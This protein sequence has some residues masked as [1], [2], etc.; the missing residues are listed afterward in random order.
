MVPDEVYNL[1]RLS[2]VCIRS[3]ICFNIHNICPCQGRC[4][5][6]SANV[7][8]SQVYCK[9]IYIGIVFPYPCICVSLRGNKCFLLIDRMH[10]WISLSRYDLF[11]QEAGQP[12]NAYQTG[13]SAFSGEQPPNEGAYVVKAVGYESEFPW[14]RS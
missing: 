14:T 6:H 12:D 5:F 10:P 4:Y 13:T 2:Y 7:N 9:R 8:I 1:Y 11:W 3:S